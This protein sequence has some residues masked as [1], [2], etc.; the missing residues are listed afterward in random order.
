[1]PSSVIS[2]SRTG[3]INDQLQSASSMPELCDLLLATYR[4]SLAKQ[5]RVYF[6]MP[7]KISN[8]QQDL[9]LLNKH[10]IEK[11]FPQTVLAAVKMPNVRYSKGFQASS[12]GDEH[13]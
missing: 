10:K 4:A 8:A 12:V 13:M 11:T 6:S 3:A 2:I 1:M 9:A 7:Q 5:V